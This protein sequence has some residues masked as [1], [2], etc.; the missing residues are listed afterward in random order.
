MADEEADYKIITLPN[1]CVD[2]KLK[3]FT[4]GKNGCYL[5]DDKYNNVYEIVQYS[6]DRR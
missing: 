2:R 4:F 5:Y 3:S 6:E 1:C